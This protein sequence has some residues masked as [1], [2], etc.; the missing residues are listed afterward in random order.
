R[1]LYAPQEGAHML[2]RGS[3]WMSLIPLLGPVLGGYIESHWG[4]RGAFAVL[5]AFGALTLL[6]VATRL[7][8]SLSRRGTGRWTEGWS[9]ILRHPGFWS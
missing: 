8:E 2:A 5:T 1:D 7:P 6:Y 4:W 3:T 9:E